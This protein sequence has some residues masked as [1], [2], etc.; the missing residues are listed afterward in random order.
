MLMSS[1]VSR[2]SIVDLLASEH[3]AVQKEGLVLREAVVGNMY[4]CE[5]FLFVV[6]TCTL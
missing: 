6:V 4:K 3:V 5:T 1:P 2:Q